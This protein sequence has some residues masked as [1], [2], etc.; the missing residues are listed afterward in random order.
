[1][2]L[3][4]RRPLVCLVTDRRRLRPEASEAERLSAVLALVEEAA[5]AGVDLIQIRERDLTDRTL[6]ALVEQALARARPHGVRVLVNDRVDVALT[7][8]A[9]GVHLRGDGPPAPRVRALVGPG[10]LVGRSVH[11]PAEAEA[12]AVAGGLDYLVFGP[13]FETVSKPVRPAGVAAL[14]EA[15]ARSRLPVLAIGGVTPER[16]PELGRAG[17]AG[18][19]AIAAFL[20]PPGAGSSLA[21]V[22]ESLRRAFDSSRQLI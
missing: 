9:D 21:A 3:P 10:C 2:T 17:A 22:V 12:V 5:A 6:L 19:A 1:M 11:D 15:V 4:T 18:I 13:V 8:G 20:P 7:A 14:A 16:A